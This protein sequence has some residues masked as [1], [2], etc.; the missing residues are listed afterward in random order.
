MVNVALFYFLFFYIYVL[1]MVKGKAI[2]AELVKAVHLACV[3]KSYAEVAKS[4]GRSKS[5]VYKVMKDF[6]GG[7]GARLTEKIVAGNAKPPK[8]KTNLF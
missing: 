4:F 7:T 5:W 6:N 8:Q 2:D 1:K 3:E